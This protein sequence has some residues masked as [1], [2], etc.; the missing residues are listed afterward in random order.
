MR[1]LAFFP[2]A[3]G[4]RVSR[5]SLVGLVVSALFLGTSVAADPLARADVP[6]PLVPWID[7]VLKDVP[8]ADCPFVHSLGK[9]RQCHWPSRLALDLS[10]NVGR[11]DQQWRVYRET[12]VPLPGSQTLWPQDVRVGENPVVVVDRGGV[13]MLRLAAGRH[14]VSGALEWKKLPES[15]QIPAE[16]GLIAL[17]L[18]GQAV[19]WPNRDRAGRLWLER[20]AAAPREA[21]R[22]DAVVHRRVIDDVPLQI[23]TD[24]ELRVSGEN[25]E[26]SLGPVLPNGFAAMS[27]TSPLPA[28]LEADG[29]LRVQVRP[30]T[31]NLRLLARNEGGPVESL[32]PPI[33]ESKPDAPWDADEVWVFDARPDLRLVEVEGVPSIDPQQTALPDA[34]KNLPTYLVAAG[35]E[36]Q[37]REQRR[38]DSDPAPDQLSLNRT[39]WLDF[40]GS[41]YTVRDEISGALRRSWRLEAVTPMRLGRVAIDGQDQLISQLDAGEAVPTGFEVRQ[42]NVNIDADSRMEDVRSSLP[43][44]GW[45]HD[46]QQVSSQLNLPP[47]WRLFHAG[48]VDDVNRGTWISGWTL[49]D[50]FLVLITAAAVVHLFGWP[51]GV[52]AFVTL[53]LTYP[54]PGAPRWSWLALLAALALL[55]VI[56]E[57]RGRRVIQVG[58][59]LATA[60]LALIAIP[61]AVTQARI[62]LFP[63]LEFPYM[64]VQGEGE[65]KRQ[66]QPGRQRGRFNVEVDALEESI[67]SLGANESLMQRAPA[68]KTVSPGLSN[69]YAPDPK[70]RVSTGPGLPNWAWRSVQLSWRGPV[71]SDQG[72]SL[73]LIPPWANALLC[74]LRIALLAILAL[75]LVDPTQQLTRWL[76]ERHGVAMGLA[77]LA[78]LV[79]GIA[80]ADV[81]PKEMLDELRSRLTEA[82]ECFP[83]CA[84]SPRMQVVAAPNA[85]RLLIEIDVAAASAVPLPGGH[86]HWLPKT[87]LLG[88]Q[89]ASGLA[90]SPDGRFWIS[91]PAGRHQVLLE[92]PLPE[93]ESVQ[94]PLPLRPHR[95]ASQVSGWRLDGVRDG[96]AS[97]AL[98]LV[99]MRR[100]EAASGSDLEAQ[101][102]PPF[103][104]VERSL[105]LGLEWEVRTRVVRVTPGGRSLFLKVPLLPGESVTSETVEV[106]DGKAIV[107]LPGNQT[108][109]EWVSALAHTGSLELVAGGNQQWAEVWRVNAAPLWHLEAEGIP[110][111]HQ[112]ANPPIRTREWR[113]WPGEKVE[114]AITRPAGVGGRTLTLDRSSLTVR[115]GL[116]SSDLTLALSMR[117]SRGTQH[118]LALPEGAELQLVEIDGAR[119]PIRSVDGQVSLPVRPGK[120][121][122]AI[123]WR[124][125]DSI[126]LA[127][128]TPGVSPGAAVVNNE[129]QV[130]MPQD[131]W[132]LWVNGPR[133]GPAVLFWSTILVSLLV[134]LALGRLRWTPLGWGSWFLL[135]IGMTQVPIGFA[136]VVVIWLFALGL[137]REYGSG[138]GNLGFDATQLLLVGGTVVALSMLLWAVQ[139][140]LLGTPDMQIAGNGSSGL[141]L[142][143]Y[144]DR[145]SETLPTVTVFSVPMLFYRVAMLAWALWLASALLRWLRWGW[146]SF[147]TDGYWRPLRGS[148]SRKEGNPA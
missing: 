85:L 82:P 98:Q 17:K 76:K 38:G 67:S 36:M 142:R 11:F 9:R 45:G 117:A 89:P 134:A 75:L 119:Q 102:L 104:R 62:A 127:Y 30:G 108:Q 35:S 74:W 125:S 100:T 145:I 121:T 138:L 1:G 70:A 59:F 91:L 107:A 50:F 103:A 95:V 133:L 39:L 79:P 129:I 34:W 132:V 20:P 31:W 80:R 84:T 109:L 3:H 136:A 26:V 25:R 101:E 130:E 111:V 40:S 48:G 13:P 44:V 7:W 46:F 139:E 147:A 86:E 81:P 8:D 124:S 123:T 2:A 54:E 4:S 57:G 28:R 53:A 10:D 131:R 23:E 113:P 41:G 58:A 137:R 73:W 106:E 22:L 65:M 115:P 5:V 77:L 64:S 78:T 29:R 56:P 14:R 83:L 116:R 68:S 18:R 37:L 112:S 49:L 97:N 15:L 51:W 146:E 140:G 66:I 87:V 63:A 88:G 32:A 94:V 27:L 90:H 143:W 47:G 148:A 128:Q 126:R 69:Y 33:V 19:A 12:W 24:L 71:R 61:F 141:L 110:V 114:L 120:H 105:L 60:V 96:Q 99:R 55:R 122:A 16:T 43:A 21:S 135:F 118:Q 144:E 93:R 92:G 52:L 72:L 6:E 42:G